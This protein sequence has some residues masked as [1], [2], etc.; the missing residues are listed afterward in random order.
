MKLDFGLTRFYAVA[1]AAS[2]LPF[3]VHA[4]PEP[5]G[6][7]FEVH[8]T[9]GATPAQM[10]ASDSKG[11]ETGRKGTDAAPHSN[12]PDSHYGSEMTLNG[13]ELIKIALQPAAPGEYLLS[14]FAS[15]DARYQFSCKFRKEHRIGEFHSSTLYMTP[16]EPQLFRITITP[17]GA[18]DVHKVVDL[19]TLRVDV[20]VARRQGQIAD[21]ASMNSLLAKIEAAAG[22]PGKGSDQDL[23]SGLKDLV[24]EIKGQSGKTVKATAAKLIIVDAETLAG[25]LK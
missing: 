10:M 19:T 5:D 21:D 17:D 23:R 25:S 13:L 11:R 24:R 6:V 9:Y 12:I 18:A 15:A 3:P 14:L 7:V 2:I 1:L 8:G 22:P 4:A 16:A 20:R